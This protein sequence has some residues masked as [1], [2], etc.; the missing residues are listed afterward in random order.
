MTTVGIAFATTGGEKILRAV[1]SLRHTEPD[2]PI[3]IIVDMTSGTWRSH[4]FEIYDEL[5]ALKN[6]VV[7]EFDNQGWHINGTLNHA[8]STLEG[9]GYSYV[10]LFHDDVI[11]SPFE[12]HK[13]DLSEIF[14]RIDGREE[15]LINHSGLTLGL[16]ETGITGPDGDLFTGNKPDADWDKNDLESPEVWEKL[17]P[18]GKIPGWLMGDGVKIY[19]REDVFRINAPEPTPVAIRYYIGDQD[20]Y[21][22]LGPSGQIVPIKIWRAMGGFD[23]KYGIHYDA[24]YPAECA[25]RGFPSVRTIPTIPHMHLHNQSIGF[26]DPSIG[27]WGNVGEAFDKRYGKDFWNGHF[28]RIAS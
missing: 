17:L 1:R 22:R 9:E 19:E 15:F 25:I 28:K 4:G 5:Y 24:H 3:Y 16:M 10:C 26:F 8:M 13:Y 2:L 12:Q 21:T 6:V 11:F 14:S 27:L 7:K 18:G 23:Q 20:N